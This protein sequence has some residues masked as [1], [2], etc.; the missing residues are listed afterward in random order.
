M[1][2]V[3]LDT[4]TFSFC[5]LFKRFFLCFAHDSHLT[6][7]WLSYNRI[8]HLNA[9]IVMFFSSK[10]FNLLSSSLAFGLK[11]FTPTISFSYNSEK[12]SFPEQIFEYAIS[13]NTFLTLDEL[14]IDG[15]LL[16]NW[17]WE[18]SLPQIDSCHVRFVFI[19]NTLLKLLPKIAQV[20]KPFSNDKFN[21]VKQNGMLHISIEERLKNL[22]LF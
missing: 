8:E 12:S 16:T 11:Q 1:D 6:G 14:T 9:L 4:I 2:L 20:F 5:F 19:V 7:L 13:F 21:L 17:E 18:T 15:R 22:Q 10:E 3:E